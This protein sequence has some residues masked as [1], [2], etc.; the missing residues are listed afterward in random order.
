MEFVGY[1]SDNDF[2]R[3]IGEAR[4]FVHAA[5]EDFG[6]VLAEA[7][8]S[9]TPAIALGE[10]G[11]TEIVNG[12]DSDIP[13]GI[14]FAPQTADGVRAAWPRFSSTSGSFGRKPAGQVFYGSMKG[15]SVEDCRRWWKPHGG[16]ST[17]VA[18]AR[19]RGLLD[20][21]P[22]YARTSERSGVSFAT[23]VSEPSTVW[24]N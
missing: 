3:R 7:L 24:P 10:G 5:K 8:A 23:T 2:R 11:A 4:A 12:L 19:R 9:G 20:E 13:T 21:Q 17:A 22:T 6:V 18:G 15:I 14:L 1:L 16:T